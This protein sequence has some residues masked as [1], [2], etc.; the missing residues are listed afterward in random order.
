MYN[1]YSLSTYPILSSFKFGRQVSLYLPHFQAGMLGLIEMKVLT[2]TLSRTE[3]G[4]E[5]CVLEKSSFNHSM[6][7]SLLTK[8]HVV[9]AMV[10]PVVM[11]RC[12]S[13]TIKKAE[14]QRIDAF[15]L[16]CW[17]RLLRVP[18]TARRS[19][20]SIPKEISPGEWLER[21]LLKR[22]LQDCGHLMWR[23]DSLGKT[24]M[25][26]KIEGRRRAWQRIRW[27]DSITNSMDMNLSKLRDRE[28]Q[29]A[30]CAAV[31]GITE[32]DMLSD[33]ATMMWFS[34]YLSF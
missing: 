21:L 20:Q 13:W 6:W 16:W 24:L 10:F 1:I 23:A 8:V 4:A 7:F 3:S 14:H 12:E 29:G 22:K 11:F 34:T 18:W 19:N 5:A 25:M 30:R 28:G 9:T 2:R 33:W 15:K 31:H 27:L 32:S 17:R 26:G